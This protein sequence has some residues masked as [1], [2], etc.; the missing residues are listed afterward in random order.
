MLAGGDWRGAD[1]VKVIG[2]H[3]VVPRC[4]PLSVRNATRMSHGKSETLPI[5][6][7]E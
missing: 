2:S 4:W 7:T 3:E 6:T 1:G 5:C